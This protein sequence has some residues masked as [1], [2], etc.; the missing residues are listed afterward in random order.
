MPK[1][2]KI[3]NY[4]EKIGDGLNKCLLCCKKVKATNN[5][6]NLMVHLRIHHNTIYSELNE[7]NS[8]SNQP[9]IND[10][11]L[12]IES[13]KGEII[14]IRSKL[15][16]LMYSC[17]LFFCIKGGD[18]KV[19]VDN[20]VIWWI[21]KTAQP[22][23]TCDSPFFIDMLH[24]LN[25]NYKPPKR[26]KIRNMVNKLYSNKKDQLLTY[27]AGVRWFSL[28]SDGWKDTKNQI[29]YT[30]ITLHF[31][32][33]YKCISVCI[34]VD[35]LNHEATSSNLAQF[36]AD[37]IE[38]YGINKEQIVAFTTDG[39]ANYSKSAREIT[40]H[41]H[42]VAHRINLVVSEALE[43]SNEISNL[44][45]SV[46]TIVT[47][48]K[49]SDPLMR[50]LIKQREDNGLSGLKVIQDCVTRWNSTY[51]MMS[52]YLIL[53][54]EISHVLL[55]HN[56]R[57]FDLSDSQITCIEEMVEVLKP[58]EEITTDI[59]G[60][61]YVTI[62]RIIPL[63]SSI[64]DILSKSRPH[65][66]L[67]LDLVNRLTRNLSE[68]FKDIERTKL[69]AYATLLDP[70]FKKILF[71]SNSD[72]ALMVSSLNSELTQVELSQKPVFDDVE[73]DEPAIWK[74]HSKKIKS[75]SNPTA[76]MHSGLK[77]FLESD[78]ISRKSD[79]LIFWKDNK[80]NWPQLH[81]LAI[82]HLGVQATSVACERLFSKTGNLI[83][84]KRNRL[85]PK[86]VNQLCFL[87]SLPND[88][89]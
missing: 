36:F 52:R 33:D 25:S 44:I 68:R 28:T 72:C 39:A 49:R 40:S 51:Y 89:I 61:Q 14:Q 76:G 37:A 80:S 19:K 27:T 46:K 16:C 84:E 12:E 31:I 24:S 7:C 43:K 77:H 57:E 55:H 60:E 48:F 62:S 20:K 10:K 2:S 81:N 64:K 70:R 54:K 29:Y 6:T 15:V 35:Q 82:K 45:D 32:D 67:A 3:W 74:I 47:L 1:I 5:T 58:F 26:D 8:D 30:G 88:L 18:C 34:K 21:I 59:S 13:F 66:N 42:C 23:N 69:F 9:K 85:K 22:F 86:Y 17:A 75:L 71:S 53:H 63:I 65:T 11:L 79:P 38:E 4:F 73:S 50:D 56:K 87:S 83:T 41:I 78:V